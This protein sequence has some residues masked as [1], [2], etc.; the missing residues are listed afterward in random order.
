MAASMR[1]GRLVLLSMLLLVAGT[2]V[3]AADDRQLAENDLI[4]LLDLQIYGVTIV[5]RIRKSG[6]SF[7]VD[8]AAVE[9]L[10]KAGASEAVLKA[11]QEAG[12]PKSEAGLP[13]AITYEGV[14][15][16]LSLGVE[17]NAI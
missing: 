3:W 8:D 7:A 15:K 14:L 11:V 12:K 13:Q 5:D 4:S 9:R 10:R 6:L 2:S 1:W 17:E 16:L